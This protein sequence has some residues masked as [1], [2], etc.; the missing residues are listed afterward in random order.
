MTARIRDPLELLRMINENKLNNVLRSY[1]FIVFNQITIEGFHK[2][3]T[4]L[5]W[6]TAEDPTDFRQGRV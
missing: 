3:I 1:K 6:D 5:D 2:E 4:R